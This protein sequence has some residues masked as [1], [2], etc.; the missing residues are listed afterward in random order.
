MEYWCGHVLVTDGSDLVSFIDV[1]K[2]FGRKKVLDLPHLRFRGGDSV[3]VLGSN[4]SGKSTILR[5]MAGISRPTTGGVYWSPEMKELVKGFVP[6]RG[7]V[8]PEYT[9]GMHLRTLH[10]LYGR[11]TTDVASVRIV[12]ELGLD[13]VM[14]EVIGN[15]S[16]GFQ[17]L[18]TLA[19]IVSVQPQVIFMDEPLSGLD[20]G[21]R[22]IVNDTIGRLAISCSLLVVT[23]HSREEY[24]RLSR[25][26]SLNS[27]RLEVPE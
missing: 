11:E 3:C 14:H 25:F 8:N 1:T 6:Q 9:V 17:R 13:N 27:G 7:G 21:H 24:A 16:G 4:G 19:S 20:V 15:L 18:V 22:Q 10:G 26:V 23:G 2:V 5:L 12:S